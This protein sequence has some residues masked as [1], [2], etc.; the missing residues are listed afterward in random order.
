[1]RLKDKVAEGRFPLDIR[2]PVN[3]FTRPVTM[4]NGSRQMNVL[5]R[6]HGL[7]LNPGGTV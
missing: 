4:N 5:K 1:M 2:D 3:E 6:E 7:D